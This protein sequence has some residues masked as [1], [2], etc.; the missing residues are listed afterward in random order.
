[1]RGRGTDEG[2]AVRLHHFGERGVFGEEPVAGMDGV[3]PGDGGGRQDR[4]HVEIGVARRRR[5]DA[6]A[7]V[8]Q[9]DMHGLGIGGG[10][11]GDRRDAHFAAGA[12]D[13]QRDFAAIG[14][15]DFV[16][17]RPGPGGYSRIMS[18]WPYST[19]APAGTRMRVTV[20]ALGALIWLKVFIASMSRSVC[21]AVTAWP[22]LTKD[23]APGSGER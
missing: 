9:A 19:G 20:P 1:M 5:A 7:F 13:P 11:H 12:L 3:R 8:G 18:G 14:D 6:H 4:R 23:G 22:R 2:Q 17:H 21:P 15:Q 16:E 10:M